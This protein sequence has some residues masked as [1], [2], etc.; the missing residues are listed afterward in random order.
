MKKN[1][2]LNRPYTVGMYLL[3]RLNELGIQHIFGVPGDYNLLFLDT[4]LSHPNLKWIG[5]CNELNAAYAADG[6]ARIHGISAVVT[7]L[8]VGELIALNG[9]AGAFAEQVP[10]VKITGTPHTSIVKQRLPVHHTLG[11]GDFQH[12]SNIYHEVTAAQAQL[13]PQN[14]SHEIDRVLRICWIEK[15]PVQINLPTNI[16]NCPIQKPSLPLLHNLPNSNK[17]TLKSALDT[18]IPII[19]QA[20]KPIILADFEVGRFQV[21]HELYQLAL[22][23]GFP[24]ATLS[25]GKGVFDETHP[26]FIGI[27]QGDLSVPYVQQQVDQADCILSIGVKLTDLITGGFSQGFSPENVVDIQ[28]NMLKVKGKEFSSI[29][30]KD[31]LIELEQRLQKQKRENTINI[32]SLH[33]RS[34]HQKSTKKKNSSLTQQYFWNRMSSFLQEKD[35]ILADLG[36]AFYGASDLLLPSQAIFISQPLW[37]SIGYTLPA[38]LGTQLADPKRRHILF[39][40]DGGLQQTVQELSTICR[41]GLK[42][43]IFLINNDGYTIERTI[44]GEKQSYNDIHQWKYRKIPGIFSAQHQVSHFHVKNTHKL[45]QV[46]LEISQESNRLI[47]VEI[48]ME[49]N[50][51]PEVL[52]RLAKKLEA[53]NQ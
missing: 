42:P 3:D 15:R 13:T 30:M 38:L 41:Q 24:V 9:I 5:N 14:A 22:T 34:I 36:T 44:H 47:F 49:R 40:G 18:I 35:V 20:K 12:F 2:H 23:T 7:T 33:S 52:K 51:V 19:Q 11:D 16:S 32:H 27:Y 37:G 29:K 1:N 43:I 17:N 10:I 25:M 31:V 21:K 53:N 4:I 45:E 28:P 39:I 48:I 8:G 6:Y 46:L 50:D 26:Q